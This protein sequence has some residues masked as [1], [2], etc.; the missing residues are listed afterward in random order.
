MLSAVTSLNVTV[1]TNPR[2]LRRKRAGS[3]G[4]SLAG[5]SAEIATPNHI[6]QTKGRTARSVDI[7]LDD[8]VAFFELLGIALKIVFYFLGL[9]KNYDTL[10]SLVLL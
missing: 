9:S 8:V 3:D 10:T 6:S 1:S 4:L 7:M 2:G 5:L